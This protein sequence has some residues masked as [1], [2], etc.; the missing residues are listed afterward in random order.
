[1][2]AFLAIVNRELGAVLR[3]RTIVIALLIQ[4]F[5]ASFSSALLL[6]VLSVYD[7]ETIV[8][9]EGGLIHIGIVGD[10]NSPLPSLIEASGL[11]VTSY[12]T[13][14]EAEAAFY[15]GHLNAILTVP[16]GSSGVVDVKLY[17]ADKADAANSLIRMVIQEP[18]KQYENSLRARNGIQVHYTDLKGKP[19]TSFELIYS[20][21]LPVL[22][23][24]P[25]FVAGSMTIDSITEEVEN[26]TLPTLLST[27]ITINRMIAAKITA[28]IIL[29]VAQ[30]AAWL[31]LLQWNGIVVQNRLWVLAL[32][33]TVAGIAATAAALGTMMFKDRERSQFVYSLTL[34]AAV[35]IST[36][37]DLSPIKTLSRLAIGDA[38]T[39]GWNVAVFLVPL[40]VLYA[41]SL[42][43]SRRL[44]G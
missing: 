26:N 12:G 35:A 29:A 34:L 40:C 1:M 15:R 2:G 37:L 4:L 32:A 33:V 16:S 5:I 6:G 39:N 25:A 22:M 30:C 10:P 28:T 42:R 18:L 27:P 8:Q 24:F 44:A 31:A 20:I 36:L 19:A 17:L 13:L 9:Y 38:Y 11:G 41:L 14:A 21:I 23:F 3:D 43:V 7:P